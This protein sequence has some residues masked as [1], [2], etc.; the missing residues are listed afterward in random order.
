MLTTV[1]VLALAYLAGAVPW[2]NIVARL[3]AGVDLR[4]VGTGTSGGSNLYTVAGFPAMAVGGLADIAM[5]A[6]GPGVAVWLDQPVG[7][8][9][10]AGALAVVGHNWSVFHRLAGGR[11]LS[12][13]MGAALVLAWPMTVLVAAGMILGRLVRATGAGSFLA[14]LSS[15]P[16]LW[17]T[18]GG[19]GAAVALALVVPVLVKRVVGN[20]SPPRWSARVLVTRLVEDRDPGTYG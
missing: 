14:L 18:H 1:G 20:E 7:V 15:V 8:R 5:G 13:A 6:V 4:D 16:V 19:Y 11:G 2:S 12:T 17:A 3:A 10:L 9:V